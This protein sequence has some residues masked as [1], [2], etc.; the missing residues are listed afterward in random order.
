MDIFFFFAYLIWWRDCMP[1]DVSF[2]ISKLS[3]YVQIFTDY[4]KLHEQQ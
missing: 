4:K 2:A 1:F 3:K